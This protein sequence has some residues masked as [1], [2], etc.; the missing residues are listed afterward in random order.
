MSGA[1]LDLPLLFAFVIAF[2]IAMYVVMD[3]FDLGV[4]I[5]FLAAP[6]D[7][8]RDIMMNSL[9]PI[10][11]GNETWLVLGGTLLIAAFPVAYATLLP[12]LYVPLMVML[13]ALIFRGVAFEFR[14]RATR[15]RRLWDWSFA[16]GSTLAAFCQGLAL[17]AFI[18]NVPVQGE[19]FAGG[20]F[21]FLSLFAIAS[22]LGLVAGYALLGAGWLIFRTEGTTAA[23]GRK[24]A[25]PTLLATLAFIAL[26]SIWTPLDQPE[27]AQRWFS[28]PNILF[29]WPVPLL[30]AFLAFLIWRT[31]DRAH[32]A[33]PLLFSTLLFLL[34]L[35]GL[36][37]SIFPYAVP[38]SITIWQAAA[39]TPTLQ[40]V[41]VGVLIILP[42]ILTYLGYAH[43]VF[44]GK[45]TAGTGYGGH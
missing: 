13:F 17:G 34:A 31:I 6:S 15:F 36:G 12:A 29:L 22:G 10:W 35:L 33:L 44:R 23:F 14:F 32:D 41:G 42:I 39:S 25:R 4:G 43:W 21:G 8:D 9:A 27:I 11:D 45:T 38:R 16:G 30:T 28:V 26:V 3:G 37:I 19:A 2:G 24:L 18:E 20:P 1:M 7:A 40:F 5:L